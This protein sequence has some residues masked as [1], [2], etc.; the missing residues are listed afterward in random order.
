[1]SKNSS[2]KVKSPPTFAVNPAKNSIPNRIISTHNS[3]PFSASTTSTFASGSMLSAASNSSFKSSSNGNGN[4]SS[5]TTVGSPGSLPPVDSNY[6]RQAY[7]AN[8]NQPQTQ[9]DQSSQGKKTLDPGNFGATRLPS[10][11][12]TVSTADSDRPLSKVQTNNT[13][14]PGT[15]N[16][17]KT[18][19]VPLENLVEYEQDM[20]PAIVRQCIYVIDKYGLDLEGIYRKSANVL[21][22]SKLKEEID[23]DPSNVS[24]ILPPKNYGDSD[25]YLVGSLLKA[26]FAAL[27]ESLLPSDIGSEVKACLS[28]A[29][30][31]TRKN[32]MHGLIYKLPDAQYWTLRALLFHLKRVAEH[33][34]QNRMNA[35]SLN[36]IW[37]P[38]IVAPSDDDPNDVNYQIKAMEILF[39]VADQAFEGE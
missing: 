29:D 28:I 5:N 22:V 15:Q 38:T 2:S 23:K 33:E 24:M 20:V 7:P 4:L 11:T 19:G 31:N 16:N 30:E 10:I 27:P 1:M 37:G 17:F 6:K 14:P 34:S 25:I 9:A 36:I 32:Y 18:F 21:D 26:F 39:N 8:E 35:K 13:M 3:S 12:T